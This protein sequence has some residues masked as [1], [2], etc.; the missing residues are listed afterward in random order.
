MSG[1]GKGGKGLGSKY[2]SINTIAGLGTVL[3]DDEDS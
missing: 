3:D 1:R 2:G